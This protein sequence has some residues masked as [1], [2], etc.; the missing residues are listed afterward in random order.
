VYHGRVT[1]VLFVNAGILGLVSFQHF[2]QEF[3]P[4]Q[5]SIDGAHIVL[6]DELTWV[7]RAIRR[8]MCQRVWIDG[9]FGVRNLDLARLRHELHAGVLARRRIE[10]AGPARYQVIH[11]HRQAAAYGSLDLM[12]RVPSVVSMDCTQAC[13]MESATSTVEQAS[14]LPNVRMDGAI[15]RRAAAVVSTSRWAADSLHEYYPDCDTPVHVM[16]NPVLLPHFERGWIEARRTRTRAGALPRLLFMGGDFPRKGGFDLLAAWERG[17]FHGRAEL[18]IVTNWQLKE[19]LPPG[20]LHTRNI[21]AHSPE[22][23]RCWSAA[24]AFVMP[25]RNEAFGLV[26]QEAAAAGIPAIGTMHNAVPEIIEDGETGLLV[27]V[28]DTGKL[29]EAMKALVESA[30]LR[31]RLGLQARGRIERLASPDIYMERLAAILASAAQSR[32][33]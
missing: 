5:S 27:P 12:R 20:V 32:T 28:G 24:D 19:P 21:V 18:E 6:T 26:Y 2:L 25:T 8:A 11:F 17:N 22:W 7:D 3:L 10:S 1:R 30:E 23:R 14:Y 16:P 31:G 15:F 4:L 13:V 33:T 29:V 9:A